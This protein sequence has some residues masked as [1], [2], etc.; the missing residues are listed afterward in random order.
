MVANKRFRGFKVYLFCC[1]GQ[2]ATRVVVG[3]ELFVVVSLESLIATSHQLVIH[4]RFP[5]GALKYQT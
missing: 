4:D 1:G 5:D 2:L 3:Q